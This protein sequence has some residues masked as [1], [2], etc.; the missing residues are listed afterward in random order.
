MSEKFQKET[1]K[2]LMEIGSCNI[3]TVY[4]GFKK[5]LEVFGDNV[6]DFTIQMF[7]FFDNEPLRVAEFKKVQIKLKIATHKF[8][9]RVPS[10]WLTL[11]DSASRI[12]EQWDVIQEYFFKW[13]PKNRPKGTD[14]I[15][16][17]NIVKHLKSGTLKGEKVTKKMQ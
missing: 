12:I 11:H 9:K 16:Y 8:I 14:A 3:H 10:R 15:S 7:H 4:N 13:L 5:G 17:K 2:K 6:S 1:G